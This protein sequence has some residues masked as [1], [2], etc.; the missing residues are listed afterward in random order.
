VQQNIARSIGFAAA[1]QLFDEALH[2]ARRNAPRFGGEQHLLLAR[3]GNLRPELAVEQIGVGFDGDPG[4]GH[5]I[6]ARAQHFAQRVHFMAHLFEQLAHSI[7][8]NFAALEAIEREANRQVFGKFD[9]RGAV[10]LRFR[11]CR[12]HSGERLAQSHLCVLRQMRQLLLPGGRVEILRFARA[13]RG[14][15]ELREQTQKAMHLSFANRQR[16]LGNAARSSSTARS[17]RSKSAEKSK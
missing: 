11:R 8:A 2:V 1:Q 12:H 3:L 6:F 15:A 17:R 5:F 7:D 10:E 13:L 16:F 9:E 14:L 4:L